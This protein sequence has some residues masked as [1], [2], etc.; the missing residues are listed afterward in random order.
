MATFTPKQFMN[1]VSSLSRSFKGEVT[2]ALEDATLVAEEFFDENFD[3]QGFTDETNEPWVPNT[4]DTIRR[5]GHS[6]ILK[7]KTGKL[8][9]DRKSAIGTQ[10]GYQV[11]SVWYKAL[12]KK[13]RD[14]AEPTNIGFINALTGN[15]VPA[16]KFIGK[17]TK[18][19][20]KLKKVFGARLARSFGINYTIGR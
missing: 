8:R 15:K 20:R 7:G 11:G 10:G 19:N 9:R 2:R 4:P 3:N 5:K 6:K 14:Y 16:R 18:L 13:G 17:S 12:S 1:Q